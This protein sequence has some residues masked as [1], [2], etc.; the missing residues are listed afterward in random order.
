MKRNPSYEEEG[1]PL[2]VLAQA[3]GSHFLLSLLIHDRRVARIFSNDELKHLKRAWTTSIAP[4][5][6]PS[7]IPSSN[8]ASVHY[9][10]SEPSSGAS[11]LSLGSS[12]GKPGPVSRGTIDTSRNGMNLSVDSIGTPAIF[13]RIDTYLVTSTNDKITLMIISSS[14][15]ASGLATSRIERLGSK[16]F[17]LLDVSKNGVKSGMLLRS[18][19]HFQRF[20]QKV[21]KKRKIAIDIFFRSK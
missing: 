3:E 8:P 19:K 15:F 10:R 12:R 21:D 11:S 2:L 4:P 17:Y 16:V 7:N 9:S 6:D 20:H 18:Y 5:K 1:V 13:P 14:S